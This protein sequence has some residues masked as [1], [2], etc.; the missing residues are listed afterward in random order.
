MND[1]HHCKG[2]IYY[3][4]IFRLTKLA[5]LRDRAILSILGIDFIVTFRENKRRLINNHEVSGSLCIY[6]FQPYSST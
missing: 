4:P 1:W 3:R 2:L 5:F 6:V